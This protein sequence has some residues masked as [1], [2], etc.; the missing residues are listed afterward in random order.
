MLLR[1]G[2]VVGRLMGVCRFWSRYC[3]ICSWRGLCCC[4]G[5]GGGRIDG[6]RCSYGF[7]GWGWGWGCWIS[8]K[9]RLFQSWVGGV[10]PGPW[11]TGAGPGTPHW[12]P[13]GAPTPAAWYSWGWTSCGTGALCIPVD[14]PLF[15]SS[16]NRALMWTLLGSRSAAR[17]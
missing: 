8:A 17:W 11:G 4:R 9:R 12:G 15:R 5:G 1:A 3:I 16:C 13:G 6:S 7:G 14:C 10:G 2:G